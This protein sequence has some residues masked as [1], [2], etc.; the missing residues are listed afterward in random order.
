MRGDMTVKE[1]LKSIARSMGYEI[2]R[3]HPDLAEFLRSR[4]VNLVLD[5]GA[6][7]GQFAQELRLHG[8]TGKIA[9]F[10]PV[11]EAFEQLQQNCA[12]DDNWECRKMALGNSTGSIEINVS[13]STAMSSIVGQTDVGR[14]S[15]YDADVIRVDAVQ[16]TTLDAIFSE[17]TDNRVFLKIDTQGFGRAY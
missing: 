10:E 11:A 7:E 17:Y 14:N 4:S 13:K 6:N 16:I 8:Y 12:S 9:S 15:I 3:H 2:R 5:I 1:R